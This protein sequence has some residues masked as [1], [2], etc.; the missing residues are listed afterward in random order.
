VI[1][2]PEETE[3]IRHVPF[4]ES[5]GDYISTA[6]LLKQIGLFLSHCLDVQVRHRFLLTC[7]VLATWV[8]DQLPLAPYVAFVGLPASGKSTALRALRLVCRRG[9]LTSDFSSAAFY[10]ACDKLMPTLFIDETATVGQQRTLFHLL[11]AGNTTDFLA[12][13]NN[14]SYRSYGPKVFSW[15]EL[16]NDDALNSRCLIVPMVESSR[17]DLL[18]TTDPK[19]FTMARLLQGQ[20]LN[21]RFKRYSKL[22]S[23]QIPGSENLSSRNRDLYESLSLPIAKDPE[24]CALLLECMEQQSSFQRQPLAPNHAAVLETLFRQ[25]HVHIDQGNFALRDLATEANLNLRR[26]GERFR[27]NPKGVG[28]VLTTLGFTVRSRTNQGFLIWLDRAA[29]KRVHDLMRLH[30]IDGLAACLPPQNTEGLCEFCKSS[31]PG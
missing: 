28:A 5:F 30:S 17:A 9:L 13:R 22:Q 20:L 6:N 11:R 27:L 4:P 23:S 29:L 14:Q 25:I 1:V 26:A 10:R 8:V 2:P 31:E 16:P 19:I 7:F 18:R 12:L 21:F 15:T 3:L 24:A